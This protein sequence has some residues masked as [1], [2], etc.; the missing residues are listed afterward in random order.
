VDALDYNH[1]RHW[2]HEKREDGCH[3]REVSNPCLADTP[4]RSPQLTLIDLSPNEW[5]LYWR[6]PE[7]VPV[8]RKQPVPGIVQLSLFDVP[9]QEKA[10]GANAM[11]FIAQSH[12]F[13]HLVFKQPNEQEQ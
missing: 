9:A 8:R 12:P 5:L 10:V 1:Q 4:F 13:L 2:V 7:R 6:I 3:L 11:E